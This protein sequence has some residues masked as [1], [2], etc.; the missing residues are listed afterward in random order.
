LLGNAGG[1]GLFA[2]FERPLRS[3]HDSGV[4]PVVCSLTV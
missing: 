2:Q 1:F 3:Q 4:R